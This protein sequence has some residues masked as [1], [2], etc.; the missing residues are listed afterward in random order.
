[1]KSPIVDEA[2]IEAHKLP[3][4]DL[5]WIITKDNVN[6]QFCTMCMIQIAPGQTVRPAHSIQMAKRLSTS[7]RVVGVS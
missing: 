4:R 1:M 2:D 3:G 5:R 7:S 6:A